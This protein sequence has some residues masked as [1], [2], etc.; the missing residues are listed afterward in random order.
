M[1]E[2][3]KQRQSLPWGTI[4]PAALFSFVLMGVALSF[5]GYEIGSVKHWFSADDA[6]KN[7]VFFDLSRSSLMGRPD[8]PVTVVSFSDFQCP[9]C[10]IFHFGAEQAI[11]DTFVK[12]GLVRFVFKHYPSLGDES[13]VAAYASECAK[14]QG[15]FWEYQDFLFDRQ[16]QSILENSG[17]FSSANLMSAAEQVG[18]QKS[19]FEQ[20]L[21]SERYKE[22]VMRDLEEGKNAGVQGTP[23]VFVNGEKIEGSLPFETYKTI[24]EKNLK[25]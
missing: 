15:K 5:S 2:Y 17:I 11:M 1:G 20:C 14:E 9:L 12:K 16:S 3:E 8:A 13:F 23:T 18:L 22:N 21:S 19:M 6:G 25:K 4:V 7:A 24:I 10:A